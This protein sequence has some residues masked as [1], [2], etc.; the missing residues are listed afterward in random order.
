[1]CSNVFTIYEDMI[2]AVAAAMLVLVKQ[3]DI[4]PNSPS[5]QKNIDSK[6][7]ANQKQSINLPTSIDS[8][9]LKERRMCR[10][11]CKCQSRQR[12]RND[13]FFP[14]E[15]QPCIAFVCKCNWSVIPHVGC[16]CC[17]RCS[18]CRR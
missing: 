9:I 2:E 7:L 13:H 11:L 5:T 12:I 16:C 17:C 15:I 4:T 8:W 10:R 6:V 3:M 1:M 14:N 18:L